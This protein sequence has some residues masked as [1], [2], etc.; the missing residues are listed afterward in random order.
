MLGMVEAI[1]AAQ[2]D[3][4]VRSVS[5]SHGNLLDRRR[6]CYGRVLSNKTHWH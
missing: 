2:T 5:G 6:H 3:E 4:E 1:A